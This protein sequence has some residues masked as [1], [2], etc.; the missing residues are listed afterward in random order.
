MELIFVKEIVKF[1][2]FRGGMKKI[3]VDVKKCNVIV[4]FLW[5]SFIFGEDDIKVVR[6]ILGVVI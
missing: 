3:N 5:W 4:K 1:G 6:D 2:G